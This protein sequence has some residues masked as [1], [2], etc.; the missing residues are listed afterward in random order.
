MKQSIILSVL[1]GCFAVGA[2]PVWHCSRTNTELTKTSSAQRHQDNEFSI[3]SVNASPD[4]VGVSINDL[5]DIYSGV[6]VR[7]GGVPLSAC[8]MPDNRELTSS[9]LTS[10]G[11][12]PTVIQALSRKSAII[13]SNLFSVTTQEQMV[14]CVARHYP[15]VGYLNAPI[16]TDEV[17]P[18]F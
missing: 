14:S 10:L 7:V 13:Q 1:I 11:L 6:P 17:H 4:V 15:A 9:A 8:F 2:E 18:C 12:Q 16:S 5:I 3:A